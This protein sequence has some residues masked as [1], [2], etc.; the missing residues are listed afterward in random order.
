VVESGGLENRCAVSVP[1]VRIPLSPGNQNSLGRGD[2]VVEGR[3]DRV[4]E[5]A[6]LERVCRGNSTVGS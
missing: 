2:R 3:G 1:G 5:G 6:R 4:V